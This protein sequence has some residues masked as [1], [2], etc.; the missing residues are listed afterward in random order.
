M[1]IS[2]ATV[3][4]LR[5]QR[6]SA[7]IREALQHC[8]QSTHIIETS[9]S[10]L[11]T[12]LHNVFAHAGVANSRGESVWLHQMGPP[13]PAMSIP[14]NTAGDNTSHSTNAHDLEVIASD[15][16]AV[17]EE[18]SVHTDDGS[19][20]TC[21]DFVSLI[22]RFAHGIEVVFCNAPYT[23]T[24]ADA[25]P[26]RHKFGFATYVS[27][28]TAVVY[29]NL[30][31]STMA[32]GL[33]I[34]EAFIVAGDATMKSPPRDERQAET[35]ATPYAPCTASANPPDNPCA[36]AASAQ[37]ANTPICLDENDSSN[38]VQNI[39]AKR[40]RLD[41]GA[42]AL[43]APC[44]NNPTVVCDDDGGGQMGTCTSNAVSTASEEAKP[45]APARAKA[46]GDRHLKSNTSSKHQD[47]QQLDG[48]VD[49]PALPSI[50]SAPH[51][52]SRTC[53]SWLALARY[54]CMETGEGTPLR[55]STLVGIGEAKINKLAK[56]GVSWLYRRG[57]FVSVEYKGSSRADYYHRGSCL[58]REFQRFKTMLSNRV[59]T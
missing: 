40:R 10:S 47:A 37:L 21:G 13:L 5:R 35:T 24:L 49:I 15:V 39:A 14:S 43:T 48:T 58:G 26:V 19:S 44:D 46:C 30:F 22:T 51:N 9:I 32:K 55:P 45:R 11:A 3:S 2:H 18:Q 34:E 23:K 16:T 6:E 28:D 42:H 31:Y 7:G 57:S 17:T 36:D 29:S 1:I 38:T 53:R 59:D 27:D 54:R 8:A 20:A 12:V 52:T 4:P 25:L 56:L 33:T 41:P 50:L